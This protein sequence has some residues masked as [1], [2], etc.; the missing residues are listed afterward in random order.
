MP[1][2][3]FIRRVECVYIDAIL[4][5]F[6]NAYII[7][8]CIWHNISIYGRLLTSTCVYD[9]MCVVQ[10]FRCIKASHILIS[11]EGNAC[12]TGLRHCLSMMSNGSRIKAVHDFPKYYVYALNWASRELL[13]QVDESLGS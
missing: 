6:L 1:S 8:I 9:C 10:L 4:H 13:E 12:L 2:L 5:V 3:V 11:A 7:C